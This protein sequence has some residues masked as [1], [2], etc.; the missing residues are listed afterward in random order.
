MIKYLP[1]DKQTEL[2]LILQ[3]IEQ[4]IPVEM[5]ILFGSFARGNWIEDKY[6]EEHYRYQSDFDLLIIVDDTKHEDK[7]LRYEQELESSIYQIGA[8]TTPV[9]IL[10]HD[11]DFV[12][13][14]LSKGQ[15]FFSDIKKEGRVL[16]DSGRFSLKN[17]KALLPAEEQKLAREYFDYWFNSAKEYYHLFELALQTNSLSSAAF[18]LHQVTERLYSTLLLVFTRYK[19]NTHDLFAL[20]KRVHL[21]DVSSS[22]IF[23]LTRAEDKRL[24]TLLRK[25]Y[26]DARYKPSYVITKEELGILSTRVQQLEELTQNLC[27]QKIRSFT[28]QLNLNELV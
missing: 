12:N 2:N 16:F 14:R 18:I 25:A 19:P 28:E 15:Y 5:V 1:D 7:Q 17:A 27:N 8:I 9:T 6:N 10:V 20:R 13:R 4:T 24:F 26:V 21:I 22:T 11:I 23:P 3:L